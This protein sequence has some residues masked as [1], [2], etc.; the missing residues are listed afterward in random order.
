VLVLLIALELYEIREFVG[1]LASRVPDKALVETSPTGDFTAPIGTRLAYQ[2]LTGGPEYPRKLLDGG[3]GEVTVSGRSRATLARWF[4]LGVI[5][6]GLTV[7]LVFTVLEALSE[8]VSR[9]L[10]HAVAMLKFTLVIIGGYLL[11]VVIV[12][13]G[14][15]KAPLPFPP[16]LW[17][18]P[19]L[20]PIPG[21]GG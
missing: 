14:D 15:L 7:P 18:V 16:S 19:K 17:Q 10:A 6:V 12:W 20:P 9:R 1:H 8:F 3:P 2:Y 11:R 4:W 21:L 13:G 5:G